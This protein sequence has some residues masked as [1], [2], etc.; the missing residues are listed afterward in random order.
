[1]IRVDHKFTDQ[2]IEE[3]IHA[4]RAYIKP[5]YLSV[6]VRVLV[7]LFLQCVAVTLGLDAETARVGCEVWIT[8]R[9]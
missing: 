1:M 7:L 8:T 4:N 6:E 2:R 9:C 3:C 5:S